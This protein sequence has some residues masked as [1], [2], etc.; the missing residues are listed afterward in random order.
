MA[1]L[2]KKFTVT[3]LFKKLN[4]KDHP[5]VFILRH[6][7]SFSGEIANIS[8]FTKVLADITTCYMDNVGQTDNDSNES[9]EQIRRDA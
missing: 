3:P 1:N 8:A 7:D 2:F 6:P 4:F 9:D 5:V